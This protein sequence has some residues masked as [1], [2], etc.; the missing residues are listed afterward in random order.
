MKTVLIAHNFE[1]DSVANMSYILAHRIAEKGNRV[2]FMSHKPYFKESFKKKIG[3][4]ILIVFSWSSDRR[5]TGFKDFRWFYKIYKEYKPSIIIGHFVGSNITTVL[6]KILSLNK[7]KTYIYY[8]TLSKQLSIDIKH[9]NIKSRFNYLRKRL[10]YLFFCDKII[11][12]SHLAKKDLSDY[13]QINKGIVVLNP[14]QDRFEIKKLNNKNNIIISFLGRLDTSKGVLDLIE[15]FKLFKKQYEK[16]K[17]ILQIAGSGKYS[18]FLKE[19]LKKFGGITFFGK[20]D[21]KQVDNY[22]RESNFI[23]IPSKIDN[24]PTVGLEALMNSTPLLI[25]TETGLTKYLIDNKDCYKFKPNID[26]IV[27]MFKKVEEN[28]Y[29]FNKLSENARLTYIELFSIEKYVAKME[30]IIE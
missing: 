21:Y 1:V 20:L 22:I 15:G 10:F 14:M 23:I 6:S 2:I 28:F 30:K 18:E 24:L 17:L 26:S 3:N 16:S 29:S 27:E 4:G 11:C 7:V 19:E 5:P 9:K 8:H 12:P 13:F 25:S